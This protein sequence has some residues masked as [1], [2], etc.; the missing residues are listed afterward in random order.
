MKYE[1]YIERK[2]R[3]ELFGEYDKVTVAWKDAQ[4]A[5]KRYNVT[6]IDNVD[7]RVMEFPKVSSVS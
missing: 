6:L 2:G 4:A 7:D 5:R 3:K 1:V